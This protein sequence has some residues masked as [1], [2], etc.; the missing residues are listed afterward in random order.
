MRYLVIIGVA[1][2]AGCVTPCVDY[3]SCQQA[4]RDKAAINNFANAFAAGAATYQAA[5][6]IY[7]PQPIY[8]QP[9]AQPTNCRTYKFGNEWRT[10]CW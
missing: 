5:Q 2:L 6:P 1:L 8:V 7:Q 9:P 4:E 3:D 10:H